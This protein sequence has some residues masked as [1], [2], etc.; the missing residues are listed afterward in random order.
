MKKL[1]K[2]LKTQAIEI[3]DNEIK[4]EMITLTYDEQVYHEKRK[5]CHIRKG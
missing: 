2:D 5:Y 1:C 4:K 3:I